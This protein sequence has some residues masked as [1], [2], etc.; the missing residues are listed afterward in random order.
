[1]RLALLATVV[2]LLLASSASANV[3]LTDDFNGRAGAPSSIWT[4][5]PWAPSGAV[6]GT[7]SARQDGIGHLALE[8]TNSTQSAAI[9]TKDNFRVAPPFTMKAWAKF[10][11]TGY[12]VW[13]SFWWRNSA[14]D[15]AE[16]DVWENGGLTTRYQAAAHTWDG[17]AHTGEQV[18]QCPI[19][20]DPRQAYHTYEARVTKTS[21]TYLHDG[22]VCGT[23]DASDDNFAPAGWLVL[24]LWPNNSASQVRFPAK[25]LIDKV[26]VT[27]TF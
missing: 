15:G 1:M 12:E 14:G 3:T 10:P 26:Q 16:I 17:Y 9:W 20:Y 8:V 22:I 18:I 27:A 7:G 23:L 5:Y 24:N 4:A 6:A 19:T 21:V 13:H 11:A 2:A 25:L